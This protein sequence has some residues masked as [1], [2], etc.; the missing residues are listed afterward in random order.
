MFAR[1][2]RPKFDTSG[3][4]NKRAKYTWETVREVRALAAAGVSRGEL[5]ARFKMSAETLCRILSGKSWAEENAPP[6][7]EA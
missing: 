3:E 5:G 4:R 7:P 1:F 2:A 6:P